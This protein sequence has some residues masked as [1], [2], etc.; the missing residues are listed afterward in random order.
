MKRNDPA[1]QDA[2]SEAVDCLMAEF[3]TWNE[4]QRELQAGG[5]ASNLYTDDEL[6]HMRRAFT[7]IA[8][9]FVLE[10]VDF[11]QWEWFETPWVGADGNTGNVAYIIDFVNKGADEPEMGILGFYVTRNSRFW[12]AL[13]L[14]EQLDGNMGFY[15]VNS[16]GTALGILE[17][18][19]LGDGETTEAE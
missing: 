3:V 11:R 16:I 10:D 1:F 19:T 14:A 15:E 5:Y 18:L 9:R 4:I 6:P 12:Y 13:P 7:A 8:E 17:C 2:L